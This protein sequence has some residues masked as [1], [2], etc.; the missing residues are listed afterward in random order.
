MWNKAFRDSVDR[1]VVRRPFKPFTVEF[2]GGDRVVVRHPEA[3]TVRDD[4]AML[5]DPDGV[6]QLFDAASVLRL[7]SIALPPNP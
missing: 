7:H 6:Q 4:A 1:F 2:F 3:L 5:I